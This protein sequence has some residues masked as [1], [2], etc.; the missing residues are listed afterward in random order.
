MTELLIHLFTGFWS[1]LFFGTIFAVSLILI[2][3]AIEGFT[4]NLFNCWSRSVRHRSI[5]KHGYPPPHCDV[6][7]DTIKII[8]KEEINNE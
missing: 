7:G 5:R 4:V 3:I 1:C 6:D 2:I 8:D